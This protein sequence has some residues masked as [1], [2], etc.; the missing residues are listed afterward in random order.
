MSTWT[1]VW[2]VSTFLI[3]LLGCESSRKAQVVPVNSIT[4]DTRIPEALPE[5][6]NV[7]HT[8]FTSRFTYVITRITD[9]E[10]SNAYIRTRDHFKRPPGLK[11]FDVKPEIVKEFLYRFISED[12]EK[13]ICAV[14]HRL[15][16]HERSRVIARL[17]K[18]D[19]IDSIIVCSMLDNYAMVSRDKIHALYL[20]PSIIGSEYYLWRRILVHEMMHYLVQ[21]EA[22]LSVLLE[23][24][25]EGQT[26]YLTA[27][28]SHDLGWGYTPLS[29]QQEVKAVTLMQPL[30]GQE[31]LEW[32]LSDKA[33]NDRVLQAYYN[34]LITLG[35]EQ[36]KAYITVQAWNR[37][38]DVN[39]ERDKALTKISEIEITSISAIS[40][41]LSIQIQRNSLI[42]RR[43][44]YMYFHNI[45]LMMA[46][47]SEQAHL[48]S[49]VTEHQKKFVEYHQKLALATLELNEVSK[50]QIAVRDDLY[51]MLYNVL[52]EVAFDFNKHLADIPVPIRV[53]IKKP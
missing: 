13:V 22:G 19:H 40:G 5:E 4:P 31:L 17:Q 47:D 14:L 50:R 35:V 38:T 53:L 46:L 8:H 25:M 12:F 24:L 11:V 30:V 48:D 44:A 21:G 29:Y 36:Q 10:I 34:K 15:P 1:K 52:A 39:L 32:Y 37:F 23:E 45:P 42:N 3:V 33:E 16:P 51:V 49:L 27:L 6:L 43:N 41:M 26:E 28:I 7:W 20:N 9:E 18:R 2:F